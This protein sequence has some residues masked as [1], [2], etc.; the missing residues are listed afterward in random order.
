MNI[1]EIK[2]AIKVLEQTTTN[3]LDD[4]TN[5]NGPTQQEL[6]YN[7][8]GTLIALMDVSNEFQRQL[9]QLEE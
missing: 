8:G 3:V 2:T 4:Y 1:D 7:Y 9:D 5:T 6:I